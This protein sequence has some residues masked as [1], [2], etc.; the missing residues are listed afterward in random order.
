M[1]NGWIKLHRKLKDKGYYK[2]SGYIHL[3]VH[4]LLSVNHEPK[5]FM[6]NGE[7]IMVS[8][9]QMITG[10]KQLSE[11]TG[12][13]ESTIEDILKFL[14][15]QQQIQQQKTTKYRLITILNWKT[16]QVS[17]SKSNNRATTE[18]QQADTNKNEKKNKNEKNI[19]GY[20]PLGAELIKLF[21]D[22]NPYC[23]KFYGNTTQRKAC[24]DLIEL[25]GFEE[26]SKVIPALVKTNKLPYFPSITTPSQLLQKYQQLKDK[27]QQK[28][29]ELQ[30]KNNK[31][32]VA[33]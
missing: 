30:D 9:G 20:N 15:S 24:D 31:F 26:V 8:G 3:W 16:H 21:E 18:Q 29:V 28:K 1:D 23:K 17:D 13:P 2:R 6:W 32:K 22:I 5:E 14:E 10:R 7:I 4:L 27:W 19:S 33:F 11:D 12:I 25:Y